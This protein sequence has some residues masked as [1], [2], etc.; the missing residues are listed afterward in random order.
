MK[1]SQGQIWE[2]GENY[3][4]IVSRDRLTVDYK[5]VPSPHE[6]EGERLQV[7]KKEFCRLLKGAVLWQPPADEAAEAPES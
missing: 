7:S 1:L 5:R 4:R 3:Y 6:K 2:Q